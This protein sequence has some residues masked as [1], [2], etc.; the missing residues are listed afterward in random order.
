MATTHHVVGYIGKC[1]TC[2]A[3]V[4]ADVNEE[5]RR[6]EA[7]YL[8]GVSYPSKTYYNTY[9]LGW[10]NHPAKIIT[11]PCPSCGRPAKLSRMAITYNEKTKCGARCRNAT[12]PNCECSCR[13]VNH[14]R[15]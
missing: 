10:Y 11:W 1:K 14:G 5:R 12:G 8:H 4:R 2:K 3:P 6:E 13:G 7:S 9:G 15:G